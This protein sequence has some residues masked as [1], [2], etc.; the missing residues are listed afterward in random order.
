VEAYDY[1]IVGSGAAGC[2]LANRLSE[3]PACSVALIEAGPADNHPF[4]R[5][6]K[7]LAKIMADPNY[8]WVYPSQPE[9]GNAN[10][11]ES[12]VRGRVLGGST[13]VNGMMYVRGQPAD[14]DAIA[15]VSTEDWSWEHI[16][17]AYKELES[18]E[19]GQDSTRGDAGP[20]RIT[21]PD[22]RDPLSDLMVQ[23]GQNLG[24][25]N[26][27]DVN[28]PDDIEGIGYAPRTIYKG[29]RQS[30]ATAFLDPVRHRKNLKIFTETTVTRVLFSSKRTVG[31]E[32][33]GRH[34]TRALN[35][36]GEVILA[37]GA[38]A[39][40]AILERSGIG[41]P[42]R[43]ARLGIQLVH[44]N[45]A[46]GEN[47]LEHRALLIQWKLNRDI[48]QN[49]NYHG[50]RLLKSALEYYT[51]RTGPMSAA[52]Y[53]LISWF[54]TSR[55]QNRPDAQFLLA[56]FSFDFAKARQGVERFPGMHIATYPLR[57][58][59]KG[60]VH[61]T[62]TDPEASP[63]L[64]TNYHDTDIDRAAMIAAV[65]MARRFVAEAPLRDF[66]ECETM[67]GPEYDTDEKILAAYDKFGSC[68]YHAVG[69]CRMGRDEA[70]V[71]D[72]QLR[73]R[74]VEGLRI[75]D[76]SIMPSIP[77]GNTNGPT[78]AMAWR[79]AEIIR[80]TALLQRNPHA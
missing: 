5:M 22:V 67:P 72:P 3:D 45:P 38:I 27:G 48:S 75:M 8:L 35:G 34:G 49:K 29:R 51:R 9:A 64:V 71:V 66:I 74:G 10:V 32:V 79:G 42:A 44:P 11:S 20:L 13:S 70:S 55:G 65:R 17:R 46:V 76:T 40:P 15:E 6:P 28:A 39:S 30:A 21:M 2:V 31:V 43:L 63:E 25:T 19:L 36:R 16:G 52:A 61:I 57:P 47:L 23:T 50:W 56:P 77:S 59:S 12:W 62:S 33:I 69:S 58:T 60:H 73:V 78:L 14:F 1:I 26:K 4:I 7:G 68:A 41:D 37:G 53:E 18:H 24:W 54:K 80:D